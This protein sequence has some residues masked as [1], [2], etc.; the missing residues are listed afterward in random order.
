MNLTF[1][2]AAGLYD[3]SPVGY[4]ITT[5][6]DCA[7]FVSNAYERTQDLFVEVD[8]VLDIV[9]DSLTRVASQHASIHDIRLSLSSVV[10][11]LVDL[12]SQ[13]SRYVLNNFDS[14]LTVQKNYSIVFDSNTLVTSNVSAQHDTC[15]LL[16]KLIQTSVDALV[17][18]LRESLSHCDLRLL[19][20]AIR[21]VVQ[22]DIFV[23]MLERTT[24]TLREEELSRILKSENK[25][26][27]CCEEKLCKTLVA[28]QL[29]YIMTEEDES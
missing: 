19:V 3:N 13:I 22:G 24:V 9:V 14:G 17:R 18:V 11:L 16:H 20:D 8:T 1:E 7:T 23:A 21:N 26:R 25:N 5:Q 2:L 15:V 4:L 12:K 29:V 10:S 27:L 6:H 28:E